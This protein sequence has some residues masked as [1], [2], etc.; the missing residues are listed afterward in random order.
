MINAMS[1]M[2]KIE[3]EQTSHK[4]SNIKWLVKILKHQQGLKN[5]SYFRVQSQLQLL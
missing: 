4:N 5:A 3:T 2:H 1:T